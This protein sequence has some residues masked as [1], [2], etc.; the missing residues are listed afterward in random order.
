M[1]EKHFT[2]SRAMYGSDAANGTEPAEFRQLADG[3]AAVS[4]MLASDVNKADTS[5]Y[6]EMKQIFEKSVVAARDLPAGHVI[7]EAD[8][9]YK[10]PGNGIP[11]SRYLELVGRKLRHS[12]SFDHQFAAGDL[13]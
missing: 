8:L 3:L 11:A 13:S 1:I 5:S 7:A 10:K 9:A 2:F 12:V 6:R 4:L